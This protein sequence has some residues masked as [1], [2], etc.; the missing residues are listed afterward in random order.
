MPRMMGTG[1]WGPG[2]LRVHCGWA[3]R[4]HWGCCSPFWRHRA[5]RGWPTWSS[6]GFSREELLQERK[7]RLERELARLDDELK[8][9]QSPTEE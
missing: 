1:P 2:P 4:A 3:Q 5:V 6:A 7:K 9:L 8:A